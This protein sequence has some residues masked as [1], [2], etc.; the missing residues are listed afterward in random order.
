M[1]ILY[2]LT[3]DIFSTHILTSFNYIKFQFYFNLF[4]SRYFNHVYVSKFLSNH[5][6][7]SDTNLS[8]IIEI[9]SRNLFLSFLINFI[10][11]KQL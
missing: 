8:K 7:S 3:Y 4:L 1:N 10:N 6:R 11:F 2:N 5:N 9:I